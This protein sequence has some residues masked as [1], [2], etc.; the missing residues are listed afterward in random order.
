M[1]DAHHPSWI[2]FGEDDLVVT[3]LALEGT[4]TNEFMGIPPNRKKVAVW[5]TNIWRVENGKII[6]AW[7]NLDTVGLMR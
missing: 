4:F 3:H 5:M 6:E 7:F 1:P 2:I